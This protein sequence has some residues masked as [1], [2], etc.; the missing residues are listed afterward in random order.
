MIFLT[1]G[2]TGVPKKI[3]VPGSA[4]LDWVKMLPV[5][6]GADA[7]RTLVVPDMTATMGFNHASLL[8]YAGKTACFARGAADQLALINLF[9]VEAIIASPQQILLL[10]QTI[11]NGARCHVESLREVRVGGGFL[12]ANLVKR[13]RARLCRNVTA[14]YGATETGLIAFANYDSIADVPSAVGFVIPGMRV[15]IVDDDHKT[16]SPGTQGR[17]RF[18]S[19]YYASVFAA[20]YPDRTNEAD[21]VWWYPGDLG[22]LTDN[23]VL[24]IDGRADDVINCGGAKLSGIA[25]DEAVCRQPGINDAGVCVIRGNAGIE[26]IWI[27]VESSATTN[28]ADVARALEN[29]SAFGVPVG[30]IFVVEKIPRNAMGKLQR[31]QLRDLL[32]KLNERTVAAPRQ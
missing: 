7:D 9:N 20:T 17:V 19:D 32:I 24:C 15:E 6:G 27:G 1:S 23:G 8:F 2:T 29:D 13:V 12:S 31:G 4:I 26:E 18:R 11:E 16:L 3:V 14:L 21:R 22:R 25:L 28:L 5:T 30:R 10:V